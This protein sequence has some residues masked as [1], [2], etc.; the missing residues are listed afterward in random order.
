MLKNT[1]VLFSSLKKEKNGITQTGYS[2]NLGLQ[3]NQIKKN[4]I[5]TILNFL[6]FNLL[7]LTASNH[8]EKNF[9]NI[10]YYL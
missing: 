6:G 7:D 5:F 1:F 10:L 4:G 3:L 8:P 2:S 9:Y